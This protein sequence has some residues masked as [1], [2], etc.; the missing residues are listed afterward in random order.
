MTFTFTISIN[1]I[2]VSLCIFYL[3]LN[4]LVIK[5]LGTRSWRWNIPLFFLGV[6]I[7]TTLLVYIKLQELLSLHFIYDLYISKRHLTEEI[8][9]IEVS[10]LRSRY[11]KT[12]WYNR[13]LI[14]Q[15]DKKTNYKYE[16]TGK[17]KQST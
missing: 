2:V 15:L 3:L 17:N 1:L 14:R 5:I 10:V 8:H 13:F 9:N 6:P 11:K 4:L 7:Y 16:L 12:W